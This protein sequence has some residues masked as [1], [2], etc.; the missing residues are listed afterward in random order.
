MGDD[1]N[2]DGGRF[3]QEAVNGGEI[4]EL[5]NAFDAGTAEDHLGDVPYFHNGG[6]GVRDI[7]PLV[8]MTSAF[9]SWAN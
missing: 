4:E 8:R 3:P 2:V 7:S 5:V 1:M 6:D 9:K